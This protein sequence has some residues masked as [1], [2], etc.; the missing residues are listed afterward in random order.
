MN[1]S[2]M[3]G[4]CGNEA[5]TPLGLTGLCVVDPGLL[6]RSQPW[7]LSRNP[8]GILTTWSNRL[9]QPECGNRLRLEWFDRALKALVEKPVGPTAIV[10]VCAPMLDA[11]CGELKA[12]SRDGF[13]R[14]L[15]ADAF[16]TERFG[17]SRQP[18]RGRQ[19]WP[20]RDQIPH[21]HR[22]VGGS[23]EEPSPV[24][25][26]FG[27]A[28][29]GVMGEWFADQVPGEGVPYTGRAVYAGCGQEPSVR[30][31]FHKPDPVR[32]AHRLGEELASCGVPNPGG[33]QLGAGGDEPS[34]R[35]EAGPKHLAFVAKGRKRR[36]SGGGIPELSGA[37]RG[38]G[39]HPSVIRAES[40][41]PA[42]ATMAQRPEHQFAFRH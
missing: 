17:Q 27:A 11:G 41:D 2:G 37:V 16:S 18:V 32:V 5:T 8:F 10:V 26:E 22:A 31:P 7:A 28:I 1:P 33:S 36:L 19:W 24:G 9:A 12:V 15:G 23:G 30:T 35:A 38:R 21:L 39:H 25:T 34:I 4:T 13:Q 6:A 3:R 40:R 29:V 42:D 20:Q 14:I